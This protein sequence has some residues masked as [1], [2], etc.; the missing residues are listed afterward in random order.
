MTVGSV[1]LAALVSCSV[2]E[3]T[4]SY[5]ITRIERAPRTAEELGMSETRSYRSAEE[6]DAAPDPSRTPVVA[7]ADEPLTEEPVAPDP[8]PDDPPAN[9]AAGPTQVAATEAPEEEPTKP[10][11]GRASDSTAESPA[12]SPAEAAATEAAAPKSPPARRHVRSD[13]VVGSAVTSVDG[14]SGEVTDVLVER[15]GHSLAVVSGAGRAP[16]RVLAFGVLA[17]DF[18]RGAFVL[19][20]AA[21]TD[22]Y[23]AS[24]DGREA[25]TVEGTVTSIERLER[26]LDGG[27]VLKLR[28]GDNRLH[29]VL[30][31]AVELVRRAVPSV[32]VNAEVRVRGPMTRDDAGSL[33]VA[34]T[35]ASDR[36][37]LKVREP[38]GEVSWETL[39][40][41]AGDL[42][43]P[44]TVRSADGLE[45]AVS[46]WIIDVET[47]NATWL[48][49]E[50]DGTLRLVPWNDLERNGEVWSVGLTRSQL[51]EL[52]IAPQRRA[53]VSG[54][55][56]SRH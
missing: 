41:R 14:W 9:G 13:A 36:Q 48:R 21:A 28:D 19:D 43:A 23:G 47:G 12:G 42:G 6:P 37:E 33:L 49:V 29:R 5:R 25:T 40:A 32:R 3:R 53:G 17:W 24:F 15:T 50:L 56:D 35:V 26:N 1:C 2:F 27:G 34:E 52:R 4:P 30:V 46:G 11:N 54:S 51:N 45:L 7:D 20:E 55:D 18:D 16:A 39:F 8:A 22:P 44:A 38:S 10:A 31:P